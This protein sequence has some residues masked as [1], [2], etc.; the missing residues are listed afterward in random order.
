MG[1]LNRTSVRNSGWILALAGVLL[2]RHSFLN[3]FYAV[4]VL[5]LLMFSLEYV[6]RLRWPAVRRSRS[7]VTVLLGQTATLCTALY[8]TLDGLA[9]WLGLTTPG[10]LLGAIL[11]AAVAGQA[12]QIDLGFLWWTDPLARL[13]TDDISRAPLLHP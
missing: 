3:A 9:T 5:E 8:V 6:R 4:M 13:A 10:K 2:P 12:L 1:V 11:L 7:L